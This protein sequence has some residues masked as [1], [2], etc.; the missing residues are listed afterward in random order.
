MNLCMR[1]DT[2]HDQV[3]IITCVAHFLQCTAVMYI[4]QDHRNNYYE[5]GLFDIYK[6]IFVL[7]LNAWEPHHLFTLDVRLA[8][9]LF[10]YLSFTFQLI[11][12]YID[13]M[14]AAVRLRFLEYSLSA[15]TM[16][17]CIMCLCG[18][19]DWYTLLTSALCIFATNIMGLAVHSLEFDNGS[20]DVALLTHF[21]AWLPCSAPFYCAIT[22]FYDALDQVP[23]L[24]SRVNI[25]RAMMFTMA[26][27]FLCFGAVQLRDVL[28]GSILYTQTPE[29]LENMAI[30]YDMLSLM[31]KSILAWMVMVPIIQGVF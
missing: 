29:R 13:D 9:A 22:S 5:H 4:Y 12:L 31:A 15:S 19:Q 1:F 6:Q 17:I 7:R 24:G 16:V 27:L 20:K 26:F 25:I 8:I 3:R 14:D 11:S 2:F 28:V 10:F 18:I 21:A 23:E 30:A